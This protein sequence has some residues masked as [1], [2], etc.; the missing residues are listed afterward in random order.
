M[1]KN[2]VFIKIDDTLESAIELFESRKISHLLAVD[3]NGKVKGVISKNDLLEHLKSMIRQ[4]GGKTYND[5]IL[6]STKVSE[7]MTPNPVCLK[8]EDP[9]DKAIDILLQQEFH[10]IPVI[11]SSNKPVGMLSAIDIL[12][13]K[14]TKKLK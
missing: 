12:K 13:A 8:P 1:S 5:I 14:K 10:I 11:D 2:P 3:K 4:T 7:I 9:I 6:R